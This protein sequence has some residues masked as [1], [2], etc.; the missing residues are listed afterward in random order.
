MQEHS[1]DQEVFRVKCFMISS[2]ILIDKRKK[3]ERQTFM[4]PMRIA[5]T[6]FWSVLNALM[7]NLPCLRSLVADATSASCAT[8]LFYPWI[9][10]KNAHTFIRHYTNMHLTYTFTHIRIYKWYTQTNTCTYKYMMII[11]F[12][13]SKRRLLPLMKGLYSSN[14]SGFRF[15]VLRSH[16][17]LCT[18]KICSE[19][20]ST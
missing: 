4:Y 11:A 8:V 17:L 6:L 19:D 16:L 1:S 7:S 10:Q 18:E 5:G 15:W 9:L 13:T 14:L 2:S 12:I 3:L 20:K